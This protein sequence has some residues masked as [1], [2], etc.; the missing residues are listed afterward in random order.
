MFCRVLG[1]SVRSWVR[2]RRVCY[3]GGS[4]LDQRLNHG[5]KGASLVNTECFVLGD[6]WGDFG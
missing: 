3:W 2:L 1:V 4:A 5:A 6:W